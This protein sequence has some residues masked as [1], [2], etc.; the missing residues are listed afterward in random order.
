MNCKTSLSFC[1]LLTFLL[2]L[3]GTVYAQSPPGPRGAVAKDNKSKLSQKDA[4]YKADTSDNVVTVEQLACSKSSD[5]SAQS[6][7]HEPPQK[8]GPG[9]LAWWVDSPNSVFSG[10]LIVVVAIQAII[11][12]RQIVHYRRIE[13]AYVFVTVQDQQIWSHGDTK[14]SAERVAMVNFQNHGKTPAILTILRAYVDIFETPPIELVEASLIESPPGMVIQSGTGY[15]WPIPLGKIS[16]A[17]WEKIMS[18]GNLKLY[19]CGL[20]EYKDIFECSHTT[21]FCW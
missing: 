21:G 15:P 8:L 19:C 16:E 2:L 20:L 13:R 3:T 14:V 9:D 7:A 11:L 5:K 4:E 12:W 6:Q 17:Q 18:G 10:L 1:L